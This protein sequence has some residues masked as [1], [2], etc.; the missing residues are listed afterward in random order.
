MGLDFC[1]NLSR[2]AAYSEYQ[3]EKE[4]LDYV[5]EEEELLKEA[6]EQESVN[7]L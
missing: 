6:E 2:F 4:E 1:F 3:K 7:E 5:Q